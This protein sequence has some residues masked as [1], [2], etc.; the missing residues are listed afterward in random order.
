MSTRAGAWLSRNVDRARRLIGWFERPADVWLAARMACWACTLPVLKFVVPLPALARLLAARP[1][2]E[3]WSVH[4]REQV[5]TMARWLCRPGP[6][7]SPRRCLERSLLAYRYLG[8]AGAYPTLIVGVRREGAAVQGHVW[9][10]LDDVPVGESPASLDRFVPLVAFSA[11]GAAEP[12]R[13]EPA[14]VP[15]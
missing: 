11:T 5:V 2:G 13:R 7:S 8:R 6:S 10:T 3:P 12:L 15:A 4:Q 1:K 9:V 14:C